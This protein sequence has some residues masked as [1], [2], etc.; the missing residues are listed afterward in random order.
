MGEASKQSVRSP[1]ADGALHRV[2]LLW[3]APVLL[4]LGGCHTAD[5]ASVPVPVPPTL[6]AYWTSESMRMDGQLQESVWAHAQAYP[7]SFSLADSPAARP[8]TEAGTVRLAWDAECLYAAFEFQDSDVIEEGDADQLQQ[9]RTGDVA[10][11]F[12]KPVGASWYWEFHATP[13]S[14]HSAFFFPSRGRAGLPSNFDY[15]L[16][17]ETGARVE[18]TLNEWSDQDQGWTVEIA[19]PLRELTVQGH[20][21]DP[22]SGY[23]VLAARYNYA[24]ILPAPELSSAP[25]LPRTAFHDHDHYGILLFQDPSNGVGTTPRPSSANQKKL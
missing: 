25:R 19:I 20:A 7:L 1:F 2:L 4:T 15:Q 10:E 6:L 18:G 3:A 11:L 8:P 14:R 9:Q 13:R 22:R 21:F 24:R 23:R 5:I 17:L 16:A 12:L